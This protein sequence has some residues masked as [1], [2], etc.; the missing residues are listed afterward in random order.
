MI[1]GG[2]SQ[3]RIVGSPTDVPVAA[4]SLGHHRHHH[5]TYP[6]PTRKHLVYGHPLVLVSLTTTATTTTITITTEGGR[7]FPSS[8]IFHPRAVLIKIGIDWFRENISAR[9]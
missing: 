7:I 9:R 1:V 5:T 2:S 3:L 6:A 4:K 8:L